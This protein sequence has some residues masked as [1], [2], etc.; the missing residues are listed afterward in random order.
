MNESSK[1]KKKQSRFG[2]AVTITSTD[3]DND[4]DNDN[5]DDELFGG[6]KEA[7]LVDWIYSLRDSMGFDFVVDLA[8]QLSWGCRRIRPINGTLIYIY[9]YIKI[10]ALFLAMYCTVVVHFK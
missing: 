3:N 4:N 1:T 10:A 5:D 9:I 8:V 7:F 6:P 2:L